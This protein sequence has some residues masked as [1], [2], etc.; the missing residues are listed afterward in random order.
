MEAK[1]GLAL[2]EKD[3]GNPE[4]AASKIQEVLNIRKSPED[5]IRLI[6]IGL[7]SKPRNYELAESKARE[8]VNLYPTSYVFPLY[9]SCVLASLSKVEEAQIQLKIA[10]SLESN[11]K[12]ILL[13]KAAMAI[14]HFK[15]Y[16]EGFNIV[17]TAFKSRNDCYTNECNSILHHLLAKSMIMKDGLPP[18]NNKQAIFHLEESIRLDN[19]NAFALVDLGRI[20]IKKGVRDT[21][22]DMYATGLNYINKAAKIFKEYGADLDK[23]YYVYPLK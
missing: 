3:K 20:Y 14:F 23:I 13:T 12:A 6:E 4:I 5:Y 15:N 10:E 11:S 18:E 22:L 1:S 21:N 19:E 17:N 8:A 16:D 2:V 7:H 9:L